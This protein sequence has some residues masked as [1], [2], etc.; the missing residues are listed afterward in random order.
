MSGGAA[1]SRPAYTQL[2]DTKNTDKM[3]QVVPTDGLT[4]EQILEHKRTM[5][6][7]MDESV[8]ETIVDCNI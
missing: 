2:T 6:T 8:E 1:Q 7:R 3:L 4:A 5:H